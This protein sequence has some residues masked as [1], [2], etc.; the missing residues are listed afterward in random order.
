MS[1][2][3]LKLKTTYTDILRFALP[4]SIAILIPQLNFVTNNIFLSR[5]GENELGTAGITGVYYL[6]FTVIGNGFNNGLQSL[7]SRSAG[8]ENVKQIGRYLAQAMKITVFLAGF[9]ILFTYLFAPILIKGQ[10]HDFEIFKLASSFIKVR[11]LGLPFL[12]LYQLGNSFLI[13]TNNTRFLIIGSIAEASTNIILDYIFIFGH[14]GFPAMGFM[15]AAWASICAE[16]VG[17]IVVHSFLWYKG[18]P[19]KYKIREFEGWD[20]EATWNSLDRSAP[21]IFQY[22]I[23]IISWLVFY[24]WIEDLGSRSLAISNTMRNVFGIFGVFIWA[25]AATSNNMV[26]NVIGQVQLDQV[27]PLIKKIAKLSFLIA[28]TCCLILNIFP[29]VFYKMYASTEDFTQEAI[30][31]MREVTIA[32]LMM[33]QGAI[34]LNA[35]LGTGLTRINLGIEAVTV[36][37]YL[38]YTYWAVRAEHNPLIW[39]WGSEL[40]YWGIL[41]SGS[42]LFFRFY[43]WEERYKR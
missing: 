15:G 8:Q 21:I 34:W 27:I 43:P 4:I 39:A 13:S 22:L 19:Q 5:L 3:S 20:R 24:L 29:H 41:W 38:F 18:L 42:W 30:P 1:V 7:L 35:I 6:I 40:L 23:S 9:G 11:I 10:I 25:F 17:M 33:S 37:A 28:F 26:S 32:I 36:A 2:D 31:V 12:F 16:A 14:A